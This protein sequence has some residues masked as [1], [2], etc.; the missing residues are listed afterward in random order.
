MSCGVKKIVEETLGICITDDK[1]LVEYIN[2]TPE[3]I[4]YLLIIISE[5]YSISLDRM[6]NNIDIISIKELSEICVD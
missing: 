3:I 2:V 4:L 5:K 1:S 6:Y